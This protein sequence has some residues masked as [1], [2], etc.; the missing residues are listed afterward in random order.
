MYVYR[1]GHLHQGSHC[2]R[3]GCPRDYQFEQMQRAV[4]TKG[5]DAIAVE[6]A[7]KPAPVATFA[8]DG[9]D[10]MDDS[11]N[12]E[13]AGNWS[14]DERPTA[15]E[16]MEELRRWADEQL[17]GHGETDEENIFDDLF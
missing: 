12:A 10:G 11:G 1:G 7:T 13:N 6:P 8:L 15:E 17:A 2:D 9:M 4:A 16:G 5:C 14:F 3:H